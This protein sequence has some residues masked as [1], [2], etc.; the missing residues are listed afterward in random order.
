MKKVLLFAIIT[1]CMLTISCGETEHEFS[2]YHCYFVFDNGIHNNSVAAGAM[3]P[4]SNIFVVVKKKEQMVGNS[5]LTHFLFTEA[6]GGKTQA[7]KANGVDMKRTI[8][9]GQ[10][11]GIIIGYGNMSDPPVFY[12]YDLE[13]PNCF[14]PDVFPLKSKPLQLAS[15]GIADCNVCKR[16]YNLNAG[17]LVISG[18]RGKPLTR[19]RAQTTGPYGTLTVN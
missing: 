4:Y 7:S 5:T 2:N 6:G 16:R 11:N 1:V 9:I 13:C 14:N 15:G 8:R 17:G 12:A 18:E 3:T 10:N 19:Y